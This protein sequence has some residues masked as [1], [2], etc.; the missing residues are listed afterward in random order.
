MPS[1]CKLRLKGERTGG[2]AKPGNDRGLASTFR[3]QREAGKILT[4]SR[5]AQASFTAL[6]GSTP[7]WVFRQPAEHVLCSAEGQ[8]NAEVYGRFM[9]G[10]DPNTDNPGRF[11]QS[12][13]FMH[14][15]QSRINTGDCASR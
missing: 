12:G 6:P 8:A 3:V 2:R 4:C 11:E 1:Q 5:C 13:H 9:G 10:S 14:M 7:T 15:A